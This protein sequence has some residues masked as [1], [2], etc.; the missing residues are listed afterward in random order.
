MGNAPQ[1]RQDLFDRRSIR[2]VLRAWDDLLQLG[3]HP[4]TSL[5]IVGNRHRAKK[6]VA[7]P[8]E[9]GLSLRD[10]FR[11]AIEELKAGVGNPDYQDK[12]WRSFVILKEEFIDGR[13]PEYLAL[14][15]GNIARRTYQYAQGQAIDK[16]AN[17]LCQWEDEVRET[18]TP[19]MRHSPFL[20]PP[21]PAYRLVG[22]Y[23]FLQTLKGQLFASESVALS[24]LNG[25][26]G[27]GKTALAVA[28]AYDSEIL[29]HFQDGV[30]WAGLGREPD[31]LSLLGTWAMALGISSSDLAMLTRIVDRANAIHRA[32]GMRH[33]LLVIDD[34]WQLEAALAFQVGGPNC[35]HL[36]TTRLPS[37]ARDFAEGK[38]AVVEELSD[39]AGLLLLGQLAPGVAEAEPEAAQELVRAV[40]G[41]PLAI[42]LMALYARREAGEEG[43]PIQAVLG[44]L[45]EVGEKL[46]LA[47]PQPPVGS[48][49]SL[50]ADAPI[51]LSAAIEIS[52]AALTAA[53]R[54]TLYALSVFPPKPSTFSEEAALAVA[55]EPT[56]ELN[57]LMDAGLLEDGGVKRYTLHQAIADY[58]RSKLADET[59]YGRMIAY[60]VGYSE[61]H[62]ND[63]DLLALEATNILAA[64]QLAFDQARQDEL[65]R[66]VNAIASYFESRGLY[67][68]AE[69]H[70]NRAIDVARSV[71]DRVGWAMALRNLGRIEQR[72]GNY[73]QAE[74]SFRQGLALARESKHSETTCFLLA[75]LG[76]LTMGRGEYT[77]AEEYFQ[78][79]LSLAR[80]NRDL[81]RISSLLADIGMVAYHRGDYEQAENFFQ[82]GL[83]RAREVGHRERISDLLINLGFLASRCGDCTK[84]EELYQ[85][86]LAVA[87]EIGQRENICVLLTNLGELA[88]DREDY[89][90]AN[91]LYQEAWILAQKLGQH[92]LIIELLKHLGILE[93]VREDYDRASAFYQE[94]LALAR[95]MERRADISALLN[96]Q[97]ELCLRQRNWDLASRTFS[98]ALEIAKEI[99]GPDQVANALY[100]LAQVEVI[101]GNTAKAHSYG[102][103]SLAILESMGHCRAD[104]VRKWIETLSLT[105]PSSS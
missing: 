15:L 77:Q 16:L 99:D 88:Y 52:D 50:P 43:Q 37:I 54:R 3:E 103:E 24:A 29:A 44:R 33:M 31:I 22:R 90:Q 28:L 36:L 87:Q 69:S 59:T 80:K 34:A 62:K 96:K 8:A 81:E 95:K 73:A 85:E 25:L 14:Q 21:Q 39:A 84:A 101:Y 32:I 13:D 89:A 27:V 67:S 93:E 71:D 98:E 35:A 41:L 83:A 64:L 72:R 11:A 23:N 51:S 82:D 4:L 56:E 102:R 61:T 47:H 65:V 6:R 91:E 2:E 94:G 74:E 45:K 68:S 66:G 46:T 100:G 97:G 17:I 104:Q 58:A 40:G 86:G 57:S 38:A 53:T 42:I 76:W 7:T 92:E 49:P 18:P 70:L 9:Y 1:Q 55:S 63:L 20:A 48:H 75:N 30:L 78:E 26:P 60:F 105:E 5:K 10:V 12:R 79:G 19:E